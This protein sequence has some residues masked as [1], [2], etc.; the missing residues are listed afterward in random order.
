MPSYVNAVRDGDDHARSNG[1][2]HTKMRANGSGDS[3]CSHLFSPSHEDSVEHEQGS[4]QHQHDTSAES[5]GA[6]SLTLSLSLSSTLGSLSGRFL[7]E[8]QTRRTMALTL[9]LFLNI[10][11]AL[12]QFPSPGEITIRTCLKVVHEQFFKIS[13]HSVTFT[14]FN[15]AFLGP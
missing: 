8:S 9:C 14:L 10:L 6:S 3:N 4:E 12:V 7:Y 13:I 15:Y 1:G 2:I 11:M 5:I